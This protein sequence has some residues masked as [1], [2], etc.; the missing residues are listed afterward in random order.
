LVLYDLDVVFGS[1]NQVHLFKNLLLRLDVTLIVRN[2]EST[3]ILCGINC[4]VY[5]FALVNQE[6]GRLI[7]RVVSNAPLGGT[8]D[9]VAYDVYIFLLLLNLM[10][11]V[12]FGILDHW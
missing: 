10:G 12:G 4:V 8:L 6:T 9:L 11:L 2:V 1:I 5:Y 7:N 3:L